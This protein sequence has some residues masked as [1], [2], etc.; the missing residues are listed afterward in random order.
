MA[1]D[2]SFTRLM[3]RLQTGDDDA[4]ALVFN[5]FSNRLIALARSR[6]DSRV[7]QKIDPE[8]VMQSAFR[9]FFV[10]YA[11]GQVEI[12]GWDGLWRML[13]VIT[14]RKCGHRV[15]YFHAERRDVDREAPAPPPVEQSSGGAGE[16]ASDPEP[17][18]IEAAMLAETVEN[19]MGRLDGWQRTILELRLQGYEIPEIAEQVG[20]TERTVYRVLERVKDWLREMVGGEAA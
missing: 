19:L 9:S 6:L 20:R 1:E 10:R 3:A 17:T 18:P 4:A 14:L 16:T 5:R 2:Q 15:E 7:R 13:V 12:D 11:G 8:D